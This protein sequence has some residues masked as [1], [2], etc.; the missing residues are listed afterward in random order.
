M[1]EREQLRRMSSGPSKTV[2]R[3]F[4]VTVIFSVAFA[5]IEAAVVVYL[6]TIFHPEGFSF[7]LVTFG[8]SPLWE[9]LLLTEV[10]R[11]AATLAL[12]LTA[13]WLFGGSRQERF[14]FFMVIF[15]VWDIFYYVWLKV[16][17]DWP[18]SI[19]DWDILFLIPVVWAGPVVAPVLVS[20]TLIAFAV[21]VLNRLCLGKAFHV[22]LA[23]SLGFILAG[24]VV[25]VSFCLA[26]AH[27]REPDYQSHFYWWLFGLGN[28]SGI[29]LFLKCLYRSKG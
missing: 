7:P 1:R 2:L 24:L 12:I 5:Y 17:I 23:D 11:E 20:V 15:A 4:V 3:R 27:A 19:M 26:G 28:V 14:A 10:G 9:R 6:R 16:L 8:M 21:I 13:A 22:S 18:A 25:V 29:A